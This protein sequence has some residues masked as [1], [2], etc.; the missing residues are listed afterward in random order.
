MYWSRTEK[1]KGLERD[2]RKER[3]QTK[4]TP[5][6]SKCVWLNTN[7]AYERRKLKYDVQMSDFAITMFISL[8]LLPVCFALYPV[9]DDL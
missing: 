3:Y 1:G 5:E 7:G 4:F 9:V 8:S 2:K 6:L